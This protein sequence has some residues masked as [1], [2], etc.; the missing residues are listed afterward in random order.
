MIFGFTLSTRM[1]STIISHKTLFKEYLKIKN[2]NANL[3]DF[4]NQN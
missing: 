4:K 1:K 2:L 3:F